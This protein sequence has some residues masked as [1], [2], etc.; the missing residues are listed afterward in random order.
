MRVV[1]EGCLACGLEQLQRGEQDVSL[2]VGLVGGAERPSERE[3]HEER[4]GRLHAF[5]VLA[6]ERDAGRGDAS[7]AAAFDVMAERTHGARAEWFKR[8]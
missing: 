1:G 2:E 8:V 6:D 5:G 7:L 3:G 4:A